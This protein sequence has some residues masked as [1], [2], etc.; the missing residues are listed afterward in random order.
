VKFRLL[1]KV[2][3]NNQS[4]WQFLFAMGGFIAGLL[5]MLSSLQLYIEIKNMLAK[6]EADRQKEYLIINKQVTLANTFSKGASA[7]SPGELDTLKKQPFI[8]AVAPFETSTFYVQAKLQ[9]QFG[10]SPDI[11]F[12]AVPDEYIDNKPE[13]F[14]WQEGSDFVPIIISNEFLNIYN[15]GVAMTSSLP[16]LPKE[17]IQMFPFQIRIFNKEKEATFNARVIGFSDRI[18]TVLV[19]LQFMK[20]ANKNFG[21]TEN[22]APQ[23][24]LI[25]VTDKGDPQFR[26][27]LSDNNYVTNQEQLKTDNTRK[28]LGIIISVIATVGMLFV[29]LSFVIF[30]V[31]FQLLIARAQYEI[32]VLLNLGYSHAAISNMLNLQFLVILGMSLAGVWGVMKV[33]F[34]KFSIILAERGVHLGGGELSVMVLGAGAIIIFILML[35]NNITLNY[36][37]RK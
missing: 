5:I 24:L 32:S 3:W 28:I 4:K 20:W 7:F 36:T 15:F 23:R 11:F 37:L 29:L 35:L 18:P 33:A 34:K 25:E 10:F 27:F 16:Q 17:A 31:N 22:P 8:K 14:Q 9:M 6:A 1:L 13:Q 30:V 19:P 2:L 21:K 12:E 26:Q